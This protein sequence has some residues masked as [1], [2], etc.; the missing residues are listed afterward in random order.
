M[1]LCKQF[2]ENKKNTGNELYENK[3]GPGSDYSG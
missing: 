2:I 1:Y 3:Y